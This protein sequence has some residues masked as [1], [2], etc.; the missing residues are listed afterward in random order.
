MLN[1]NPNTL[2]YNGDNKYS[3]AHQV[4]KVTELTKSLDR[5]QPLR[6]SG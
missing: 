4:I 3:N 1:S 6:S 2:V 5:I